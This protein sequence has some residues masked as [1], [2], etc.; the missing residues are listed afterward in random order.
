MLSRVVQRDDRAFRYAMG[1]V[2]DITPQ[3]RYRLF[4]MEFLCPFPRA[5]GCCLEE[6]S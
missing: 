5:A 4:T 1:D 6:D 2:H 3:P